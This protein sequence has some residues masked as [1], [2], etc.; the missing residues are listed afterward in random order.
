MAAFAFALAALPPS[1]AR[2]SGLER[3]MF[4]VSFDIDNKVAYFTG[5]FRASLSA[6]RAAY[7]DPFDSHVRKNYPGAKVDGC[8]RYAE[9]T[10]DMATRLRGQVKDR[11]R[12][13]GYNVID[14]GWTP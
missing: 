1:G 5:L 6:P 2:A 9:W 10:K 14:T 4:C 12:V 7:T 3:D 11:A 13:D 8:V